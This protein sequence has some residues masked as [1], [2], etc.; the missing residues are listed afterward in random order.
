[1]DLSFIHREWR[2]GPALLSVIAFTFLLLHSTIPKTVVLEIVTTGIVLGLLVG[3]WWKCYHMGLA[4]S[5]AVGAAEAARVFSATG[6]SL[7]VQYNIANC[8]QPGRVTDRIL[9]VATFILV[10]AAL[11][12]LAGPRLKNPKQIERDIPW[13]SETTSNRPTQMISGLWG[14]L[15]A[16][17]LILFMMGPTLGSWFIEDTSVYSGL[18]TLLTE[19][20]ERVDSVPLLGDDVAGALSSLV[21]SQD[22]G[23]GFCGEQP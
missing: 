19:G 14:A 21:P 15:S 1:M 10:Y 23:F 11:G 2:V 7:W 16:Y 12:R 22:E 3:T 8:A 20:S 17:T 18:W 5:L 9:A 4:A 6:A 13:F